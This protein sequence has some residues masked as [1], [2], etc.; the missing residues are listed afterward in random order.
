MISDAPQPGPESAVRLARVVLVFTALLVLTALVL[1]F[2]FN[3]TEHGFFPRCFFHA[4]TG[5]DCP[6]CGGLRAMHQLLHGHFV[7]AFQFNPLLVALL[8]FGLW[9]F[10]GW[11]LETFLHKKLP[12]P[13]HSARWPWV[14]AILV[15][16]FGVL[17]NLPWHAWIGA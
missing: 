13:F 4:W 3:P 11:S 2:V 14:L 8:P 1:L 16:A 6:G 7:A 12:N 5:L 17:R 15:V 10:L 9:W